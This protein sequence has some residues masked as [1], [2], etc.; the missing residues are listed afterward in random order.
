VGTLPEQAGE[1]RKSKTPKMTNPG[2]AAAE[3]HSTIRFDT[4]LTASGQS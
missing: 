4:E 2:G 3:R 1:G